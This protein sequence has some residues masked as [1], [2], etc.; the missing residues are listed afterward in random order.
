MIPS[1]NFESDETPLVA[2]FKVWKIMKA[3]AMTSSEMQFIL[4]NK[5]IKENTTMK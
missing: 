3:V 2:G 4:Q 5:E 1:V